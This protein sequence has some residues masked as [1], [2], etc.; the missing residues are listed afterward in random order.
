M[1]FIDKLNYQMKRLGLNKSRLSQ[2]SGVPYTTIDGFYKKG[3]VYYIN[4]N[5]PVG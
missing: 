5:Y 3:G 4:T 1:N 2:I